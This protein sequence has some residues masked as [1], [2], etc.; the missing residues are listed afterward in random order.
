[1][2]RR[3]YGAIVLVALFAFMQSACMMVGGTDRQDQISK[4]FDLKPGGSVSVHNVNG[5]ISVEGWD[6]EK[7]EVLAVKTARGYDDRDAESNLKKIEI[8]FDQTG[9]NLRIDTHFP[10]GFHFG[11]GVQY[12]LHVPRKMD[13]D[14]RS[15][16]G[17]VQASDVQGQIRLKTT[18]GTVSA[19][20]IGGSL[21]AS[22]TNG[23]VTGTFSRSLNGDVSLS[24]TN[25]GIQLTLPDDTDADIS[26]RTTNGS[27]RSDFPI[28]TQGSLGKH[29]LEGRMGKGGPRIELQTTNG[30][31]SI[32]RLSHQ[33]V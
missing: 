9:N 29:S 13:L 25:G 23:K 18:N 21:Q 28:T 14:L 27:I 12:T 22:S 30:G 1:M 24:T 7:V 17:R 4:T 16:N 8:S 5:S 2:F 32:S 15:T 3:T 10:S 20:N 19:E 31:I 6:Q 11:G 33:T 26:A